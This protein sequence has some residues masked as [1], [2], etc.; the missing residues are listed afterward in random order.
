M[1]P[2]KPRYFD[3]EAKRKQFR[4]EHSPDEWLTPLQ[5]LELERSYLGDLELWNDVKRDQYEE[6]RVLV[7]IFGSVLFVVAVLVA[8]L[9]LFG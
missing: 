5:L 1:I 6:A 9:V 3:I 7:V 8:V 4:A 2:R